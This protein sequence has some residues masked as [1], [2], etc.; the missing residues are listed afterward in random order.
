[1]EHSKY[2]NFNLPSS[3]VDGI[4]DVNKLSDNFR[5]VDRIL[6]EE[7]LKKSDV[8]QGYNPLSA[9]PISAAAV[10]DAIQTAAPNITYTSAIAPEVGTVKDAL[11]YLEND[12]LAQDY[13]IS[14]LDTRTLALESDMPFKA[15]KEYV[16][17]LIEKLTGKYELIET[18]KTTED[19]TEIT[20]TAQPDG[21]PYNFQKIL[22][23]VNFPKM[24]ATAWMKFYVGSNGIGDTMGSTSYATYYTVELEVENGFLYISYSYHTNSKSNASNKWVRAVPVPFNKN[25]DNL[26]ISCGSSG[27]YIPA[28]TTYKIYGV[29]A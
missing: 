13:R 11:D 1:M 7:S 3:D 14:G 28:G 22:I 29:R 15:S 16:D 27:K 21:T 12:S 6:G 20:R 2:Y 18:I 25:I 4:A 5:E 10:A 26:I 17:G 19:L 9:E 23:D 24:T 8:L